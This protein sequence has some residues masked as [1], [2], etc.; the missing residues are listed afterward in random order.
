MST[1]SAPAITTA[2]VG[3]KESEAREGKEP[4]NEGQRAFR[5]TLEIRFFPAPRWRG[6]PGSPFRSAPRTAPAPARP[7][8]P[9]QGERHRRGARAAGVRS[10]RS[11]PAVQEDAEGEPQRARPRSPPH[12]PSGWRCL[13]SPDA[14]QSPAQSR[15]AAA[16]AAPSPG[17]PRSIRPGPGGDKGKAANPEALRVP[18]SLIYSVAAQHAWKR[19]LTLICN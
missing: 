7:R 5:G 15:P 1:G 12:S 8:C 19:L 3:I 4:D 18:R 16:A 6:A 2:R 10:P 9:G 14:P 11:L 13:S 17:S